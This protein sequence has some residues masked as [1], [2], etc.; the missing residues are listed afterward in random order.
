MMSDG[1]VRAEFVDGHPHVL[2]VTVERPPVNAMSV[3]TYMQIAEIFTSI[4]DRADVHCAVFTGAGH[5]AFIAGSDVKVLSQKTPEI[6][7]ARLRGSRTAY[8]AIR[9]CAVPIVAAVNAAAL[10]SG[11]IMASLCNII[12]A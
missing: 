8:E 4:A 6:A 7:A 11:F 1:I 5:R 9:R 12:V 2:L 3:D 10:G